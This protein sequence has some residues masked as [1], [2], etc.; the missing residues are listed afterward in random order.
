MKLYIFEYDTEYDDIGLGYLE[1]VTVDI[2]SVHKFMVDS[3]DR[4][5]GRVKT[6]LKDFNFSRYPILRTFMTGWGYLILDNKSKPERA[7]SVEIS[8]YYAHLGL[9]DWVYGEDGTKLVI[10][11]SINKK[12]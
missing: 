3:P 9:G 4:D 5:N 7:L 1:K 12:G 6:V 10:K 8:K 2:I 11:N